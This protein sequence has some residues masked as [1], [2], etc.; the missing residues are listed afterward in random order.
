MLYYILMTKESSGVTF[1]GS[2]AWYVDWAGEDVTVTLRRGEA[3]YDPDTCAVTIGETDNGGD[4]SLAEAIETLQRI[5]APA[6]L[7]TWVRE[8]A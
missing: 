4:Y 1:S 3:V 2:I 6:E 7:V 8:H 5:D